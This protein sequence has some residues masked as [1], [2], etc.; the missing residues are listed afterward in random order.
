MFWRQI[1]Y[2]LGKK[3]GQSVRE[4]EVEEDNGRTT[5]YDKEV[6]VHKAIWG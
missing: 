5:E 6:D 3:R 4:V 1:N 2:A